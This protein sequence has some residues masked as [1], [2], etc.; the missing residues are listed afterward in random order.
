VSPRCPRVI[1]RALRYW[2]RRFW[3]SALQIVYHD[4]Y[5][6]SFPE[7]PV[8]PLRAVRIVALLASVG[9]VLRRSVHR[10]EPVWLKALALV[11]TPEYLDA[12]HD[13]GKMI[14]IMGV[15][16]GAEQIDRLIQY[17]RLQT[18]GTL[19]AVRRARQRGLAVN[20][21]GGYH[22]AAAGNGGGFCIFN[23][24]AVAIADERRRG[25]AG[26]VLVV[27]LDLHDGDGTRDIFRDDATVHTYSVHARHWGPTEAVES[28]AIELGAQVADDLYLATLRETLP[29]LFARFRPELV[30]YLAGCDPAHDDALGDWQISKEAMLERDRLVVGLCRAETT[31]TPLAIVLAGGYGDGC[32]RYTARFLADLEIPG[33]AIEPPS[34]VEITIK[35]YRYISSLLDPHELSGGKQNDEF[36]LTEED[37]FLPGW[38]GHR[39]TRFLGFYTRH[40]LELVLE[41]TGFLDRLRGLGF[42]HPTLDIQLEDGDGNTLRL[43]GDPGHKELL[44]ELRLQR[45]RRLLPGFELL[46]VEWLLMQNPRAHFGPQRPPMPGQK[47][48]GLG[49]L[50]DVVALLILACDRLHLD[51]LAFVPSQ[52]HVAAYGRSHMTFLR[53]EAQDAF[54]ALLELFRCRPLAE[55][56]NAVAEGKVIDA[57]TGEPFHWQAEPMVLAVS[58][59]MREHLAALGHQEAARRGRRFLLAD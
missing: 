57:D 49:L 43:F 7:A 5:A 40:G 48:P 10:P 22:H 52:F 39:E 53:P 6:V 3:P 51:G 17:Q 9:L 42:S 55:A 1:L 33:K 44:C 11:H 19:M 29:P 16:V 58:P 38:G 23:D 25:F 2:R 34:T 54:R 41:R 14:S 47:Y 27:D 26:R 18:G 30:I 31:R 15:E 35:R 24:V 59:R 45:D 4:Q 20:L 50:D 28:T 36:G 37:L 21:G 46:S 13:V 12:V 56:S 8:V 32:W